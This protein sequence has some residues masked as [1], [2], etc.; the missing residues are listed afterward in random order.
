MKK[1]N[2]AISLLI[3]FFLLTTTIVGAKA[4]YETKEVPKE[5]RHNLSEIIHSSA[6]SEKVSHW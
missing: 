5:E 4:L 3:L 1:R 6:K 2:V